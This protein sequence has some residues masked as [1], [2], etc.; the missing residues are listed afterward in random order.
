MKLFYFSLIF[1]AFIFKLRANDYQNSYN[2]SNYLIDSYIN[3]FNVTDSENDDDYDYNSDVCSVDLLIDQFLQLIL[4]QDYEEGKQLDFNRKIEH[5]NETF[6]IFKR[7]HQY[8]KNVSQKI[9]PI[10]K[11]VM[12]RISEILLL[13]DLPSDCM[14]SLVRIGQ[15]AQEGQQWAL[16][17]K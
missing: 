8:S 4:P 1:S 7:L 17:C 2:E 12:P 9:Q 11:R 16:K 15:S 13:I 10:I 5:L 3:E 6:A 14:A